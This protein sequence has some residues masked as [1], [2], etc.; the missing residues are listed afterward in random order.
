MGRIIGNRGMPTELKLLRGVKRE[1]KL[2]RK[3]PKPDAVEYV[4]PPSHLTPEEINYWNYYYPILHRMRVM[5]IADVK[6]LEIF[7]CVCSDHDRLKKLVEEEG[8]II[9]VEQFSR[10]LSIGFKKVIN[11]AVKLLEVARKSIDRFGGAL[12][13]NPQD[14]SRMQV[15]P[16]DDDD[17]PQGI[18][19]FIS[20]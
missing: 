17:K 9:E 4:E 2:N 12:A 13:L 3:E 19:A 18:A 6:Q 16:G 8:D 14:R 20:K 7:C 10:G 11:P 5:T 1:D 15:E